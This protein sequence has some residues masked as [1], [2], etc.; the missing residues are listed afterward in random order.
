MGAMTG[1]PDNGNS[2]VSSY[3]AHTAR[4]VVRKTRPFGLSKVFKDR[5]FRNPIH[6]I[7]YLVIS[8]DCMCML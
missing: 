1:Q 5:F 2:C 8:N 4:E 6:R 3:L 7:S